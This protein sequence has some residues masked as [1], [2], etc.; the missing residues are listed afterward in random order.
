MPKKPKKIHGTD[1]QTG[2]L[3]RGICT[4]IVW[5]EPKFRVSCYTKKPKRY[6]VYEISRFKDAVELAQRL[7]DLCAQKKVL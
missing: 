2:Q 6:L 3:W 1:L 7:D 4:H 5:D